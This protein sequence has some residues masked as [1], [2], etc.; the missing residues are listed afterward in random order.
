VS[1]GFFDQLKMQTVRGIRRVNERSIQHWS[2]RTYRRRAPS[3]PIVPRA[4]PA[5][6]AYAD[7]RLPD[8]LFLPDAIPHSVTLRSAYVVP[9]YYLTGGLFK[10]YRLS[11]LSSDPEWTGRHFFPTTTE[12]WSDLLDDMEFAQLRLQGPNPFLLAQTPSGFAVDY[13]HW[14]E[15]IAPPVSCHFVVENDRLMPA[16]IQID[17]KTVRPGTPEWR[18]AKLVANALDARY[19]VF[20][21]HLLQTHLRVGQAFALAAW[22]LPT[23]HPLRPF[24]NVHTY[25]NLQV[26]HFAWEFLLG[27]S[28]Y[29]ILSGFVNRAQGTQLFANALKRNAMLP[30]HPVTDIQTR[31]IDRIPNHPYVEDAS[32]IWDVILPHAQKIVNDRYSSDSAMLADDSLF[33]WHEAL[34]EL[35]SDAMLSELSDRNRLA[36]RLAMLIYNNVIHEI[37]GDFAIYACPADPFQQRAVRWDTIWSPGPVK[38]RDVFLFEQ[39]AWSGMFNTAGNNFMNTPLDEFVGDRRTLDELAEL[40]RQL[41]AVEQILRQRNQQRRYRFERMYPSQWE[42]SISF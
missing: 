10:L 4:I 2:H 20:V 27:A 9:Y 40:R 7:P 34:R 36:E 33:K 30:L 37:S 41:T 35:I 32:L 39:G 12:G 23:A 29:F 18:Q 16:F 13:S 25:G 22:H 31:G 26:N 5:S 3:E 15:G 8:G 38:A 17:G 28:S 1:L 14:F 19:T 11:P 42:L 24:I 21:Q 6:K